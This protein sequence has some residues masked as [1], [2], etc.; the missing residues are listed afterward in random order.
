MWLLKFWNNVDAKYFDVWWLASLSQPKNSAHYSYMVEHLAVKPTWRPESF[1]I[2]LLRLSKVRSDTCCSLSEVVHAVLVVRDFKCNYAL[3][4][5]LTTFI[6]LSFFT[7]LFPYWS[8]EHTVSER[9]K[10]GGSRSF[11]LPSNFDSELS[12]TFS[13]NFFKLSSDL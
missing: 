5:R 12:L 9:K 3:V 7:F 2:L 4:S 6:A 13:L 1:W 8:R 11:R 10:R